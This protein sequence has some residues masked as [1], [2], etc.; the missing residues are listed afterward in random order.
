MNQDITLKKKILKEQSKVYVAQNFIEVCLDRLKE[1]M[2]EL[3][4]KEL[5]KYKGVH[6]SANLC[7]HQSDIESVFDSDEKDF[8]LPM[9]VECT[10]CRQEEKEIKHLNIEIQNIKEKYEEQKKKLRQ[11]QYNLANLQS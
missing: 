2:R 6:E 3:H 11:A 10:V 9:I 5:T 8:R 4:F 1:L 7:L